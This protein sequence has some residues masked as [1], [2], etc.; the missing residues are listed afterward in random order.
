[1]LSVTQARPIFR[2][3]PPSVGQIN[4][5]LCD[6]RA[7]FGGG[8][9]KPARP[10]RTADRLADSGARATCDGS[11]KARRRRLLR[12]GMAAFHA[13]APGIASYKPLSID[14]RVGDDRP[15]W[16]ERRLARRR[17]AGQSEAN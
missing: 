8:A 5:S 11:R 3:A 10:P 9:L 13:K 7:A 15:S 1:M 2:R 12:Q 4:R 6:A 17:G 16:A 14:D